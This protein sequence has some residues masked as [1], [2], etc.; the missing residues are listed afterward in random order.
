VYAL[1]VYNNELYLGGSFTTTGDVSATITRVARWNGS[2]F[3]PLGT[4]ADSTVNAISAYAGELVIGGSMNNAGGSGAQRVARW[5][6]ALWRPLAEGTTG[7][8]NNGATVVNCL[9]PIDGILY[10]GGAFTTTGTQPSATIGTWTSGGGTLSFDQQPQPITVCL[11][12]T[13]G[14]TV[15]PAG[16]GP[17][18][19]RWRKNGALLSNGRGVNG[20]D[21]ENLTIAYLELPD[22]GTYDCIV[23]NICGPILS[24]SA[25]LTVDTNCTPP[26]DP[27]FNKDGNVD[28]G[29]VDAIINVI[30]GG[31][32]P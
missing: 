12:G 2:V 25:T 16:N 27:D 21:S 14:F 31:A 18:T 19:Y 9:V 22:E 17:F 1:G 30:A 26:C 7:G 15:V 20:A 5:N 28:Q 4:G 3:S 13:A 6:G 29:D 24:A 10:V 8:L 23:S 32:C 11:T